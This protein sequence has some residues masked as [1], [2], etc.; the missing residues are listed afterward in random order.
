[1]AQI[2]KEYAVSLFS[3]AVEN[4]AEDKYLEEL[5]LVLGAFESDREY[6][7]L[8]ASPLLTREERLSII[9]EAFS[10]SLSEYVLSFIKILCSSGHIKLFPECVE[11]YGKMYR[12][13]KRTA[14]VKVVSAAELTEDEKRRIYEKVSKLVGGQCEISYSVDASLIGGAVIETENAVIDGSLRKSLQEMKEVI[15]K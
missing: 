11:E 13:S 7:E 12:E 8:L 1:M 5:K 4:S 15:K 2:S 14:A 9:D 6:Y 3:L 10:S